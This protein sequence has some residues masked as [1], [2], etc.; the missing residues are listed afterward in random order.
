MKII[1]GEEENEMENKTLKEKG[2]GCEK[3]EEGG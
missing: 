2:R 1:K 3:E